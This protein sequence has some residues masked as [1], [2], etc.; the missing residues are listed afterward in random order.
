ML[1]KW[2][3]QTA[4]EPLPYC[5]GRAPACVHVQDRAI[6]RLA[7]ERE[8]KELEAQHEEKMQIYQAKATEINEK[9]V[10][11]DQRIKE[12]Q[13]RVRYLFFMYET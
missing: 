1:P 4:T 12:L 13:D 2:S 6:A 11:G 9:C 7:T 3:T 10:L 5:C 8:V